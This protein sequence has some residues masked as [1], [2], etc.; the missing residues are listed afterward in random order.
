M[1]TVMSRPWVWFVG[2]LFCT[3]PSISLSCRLFQLSDSVK[4]WGYVW[5]C[6]VFKFEDVCFQLLV[7][8]LTYPAPSVSSVLG[9]LWV[10]GRRAYLFCMC[11][12]CVIYKKNPS[13]ELAS[14]PRLASLLEHGKSWQAQGFYWLYS[15]ISFFLSWNFTQFDR[16]PVVIMSNSTN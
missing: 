15:R 16:P 6:F 12:I 10:E 1:S 14:A 8:A 9:M 3:C 2:L 4:G 11:R 7:N 13:K 5:A